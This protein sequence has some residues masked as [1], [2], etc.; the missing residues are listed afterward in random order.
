MRDRLTFLPYLL[1]VS[2][3]LAALAAIVGLIVAGIAGALGAAAGVLFIAL[4]YCL[5]TLFIS[6]VE[7]KNRPMMLPATMLSYLVKLVLLVTLIEVLGQRAWPGLR[8]MLFGVAAAA[9]VW[10]GAQSWW[11]WHAKLLYVEL[12]ERK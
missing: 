11:L 6:W 4:T 10:I 12:P 2:G 1:A 8:P 3:V 5:S 9:L 7:T